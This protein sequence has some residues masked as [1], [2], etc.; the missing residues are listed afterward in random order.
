MLNILEDNITTD[1]FTVVEEQ[2]CNP[3]YDD[4]LFEKVI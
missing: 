4:V 3:E 2:S 1:Y